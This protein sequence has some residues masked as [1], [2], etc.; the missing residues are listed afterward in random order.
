MLLSKNDFF[1]LNGQLAGQ[2]GALP[3]PGKIAQTPILGGSKV[4]GLPMRRETIKALEQ[5]RDHVANERKQSKML[6]LGASNPVNNNKDKHRSSAKVTG[7]TVDKIFAG[8]G[9]DNVAY[10][11]GNGSSNTD[12]EASSTTRN[13]G[14][15]HGHHEGRIPHGHPQSNSQI[16][17]QDRNR[18]GLMSSDQLSSSATSKM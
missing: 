2:D 15:S 18:H 8:A 7:D 17:W 5:R 6:T 11:R 4:G 3:E 1:A 10:D 13:S 9:V 12:D 16:T 14:R